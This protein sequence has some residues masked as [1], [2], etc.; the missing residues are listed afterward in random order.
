M[1]T[2][3]TSGIIACAFLFL[4]GCVGGLHTDRVPVNI[5]FKPVIGHDTRAD[6]S[7]PLPQDCRFRVW[8]VDG[9]T[10]RTYIDDETILYSDGW[11][12]TKDWPQSSLD[13]EACFPEDLQVFF[14]PETGLGMT[15]FDCSQGNV[16]VLFAKAVDEDYEIDR[17]VTLSFDHILSRVEFRMIQS[18]SSG[19]SVRVKKIELVGFALAGDYN[20]TGDYKWTTSDDSGTYVVFDAGVNPV[21]ITS[22][23]VYLG[24]D[25]FTIPQFCRAG[26]KVEFDIRFG[27]SEWIP[28]EEWIEKLDT[29]WKSSTHYTYTLNLTETKLVYTTGISNWNNRDE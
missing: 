21:D 12:S 29:D 3:V 25:F 15:G 17:L 10:G 5:G 6:E 23:P 26:V 18:L 9:N 28:Q 11:H 19:M 13:F 27:N 14:S 2:R 16:D 1:K 7:V 4:A 22:D 8:A 20:V 24:D